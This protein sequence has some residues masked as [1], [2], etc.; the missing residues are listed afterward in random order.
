MAFQANLA[1]W[2]PIPLLIHKQGLPT[3]PLIFFIGDA[4][5]ALYEPLSAT[6]GC[7]SSKGTLRFRQRLNRGKLGSGSMDQLKA[8]DSQ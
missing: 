2:F 5:L 6:I 8:D 3:L 4:L 1:H 7:D